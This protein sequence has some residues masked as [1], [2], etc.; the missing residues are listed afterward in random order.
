[1]HASRG[2]APALADDDYVSIP[3]IE[4]FEWN[5]ECVR[6]NGEPACWNALDTDSALATYAETIARLAAGLHATR[7]ADP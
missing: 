4:L 1:M 6:W 5:L 2:N 3:P 7:S